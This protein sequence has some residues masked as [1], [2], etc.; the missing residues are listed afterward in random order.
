[1]IF[2]ILFESSSHQKRVTFFFQ[3]TMMACKEILQRLEP[4]KAKMEN[5]SWTELL[6]A[7][8]AADV[9]LCARYMY[10]RLCLNFL[11]D[12][13]FFSQL[14]KFKSRLNVDRIEKITKNSAGFYF[15]SYSTAGISGI[16][17]PR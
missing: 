9:D 17:S 10:V 13:P 4:I 11:L 12:F 1:M 6:M 7:A 8:H 3:A 14:Q 15:S 5:A 16:Y 2:S